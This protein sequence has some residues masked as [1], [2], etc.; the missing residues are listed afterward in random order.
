MQIMKP[1]L[2]ADAACHKGEQRS[3]GK[4][5]PCVALRWLQL[6]LRL[7]SILEKRLAVGLG[8]EL[9]ALGWFV[10]RLHF[11]M[12]KMAAAPRGRHSVKEN[13]EGGAGNCKRK[14]NSF[15]LHAYSQDDVEDSNATHTFIN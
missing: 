6:Q 8:L 1:P 10:I 11:I 9:V 3:C 5:K 4:R 7:G 15:Q 14:F 2:R 13:R 12:A